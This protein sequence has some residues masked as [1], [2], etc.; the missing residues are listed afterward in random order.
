MSNLSRWATWNEIHAQPDIWEAWQNN[1]DYREVRQWIKSLDIEEVWFCGAGTSAYIGDIIVAGLEGQGGARLRA[2]AS[3]DL[4]SRPCEYL[5][6]QSTKTLIVSFGRSGNSAESIGTLE[7]L[8]AL[9][10][11]CPRLHIT[12][13]PDS[14]LA[15]A[16]SLGPQKTIV[17]PAATHDAGFAMTSSFS[18]MCYT[19][20]LL[21]D[22]RV[23]RFEN[24]GQTCAINKSAAPLG[25]L[26]S[27]L[28]N[29]LGSYTNRISGAPQRAVFLGS[30][31]LTYAARESALKVLELS[32]GSIP[33]VWDSVLGFRHGP[34]SF[35]NENTSV[36]VFMSPDSPTCDY[37]RDLVAELRQQFPLATV[38]TI[39]IEAD[40]PVD[41]PF[42]PTWAAPVC[43]AYAQV[44][45]VIWSNAMGLNVDNPFEGQQ[46]LSRVVA[47]VTLY[48]VQTC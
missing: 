41:M 19:A 5:Q 28:R 35:V 20:L 44:A 8:D 45:G 39:G 2:V 14:V 47:D 6:N 4:V 34:K 24:H 27:Q 18:T 13:N 43:V 46:T 29:V 37:E 10:P 42:G 1:F 31:A 48:P 25:V 23:S 17:L 7:V 36:V 40:V 16:V 38:I 3:T 22:A 21:F 33:A 30:G 26:A 15:S 32:A 9:A 12:C 11:L